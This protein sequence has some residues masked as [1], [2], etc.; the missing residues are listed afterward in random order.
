MAKVT[1]IVKVYV[2]GKLLR[3]KPG[4]KLK[5]GGK[6][7][8][9]VAGHSPY[10]YTEEVEFAELDCT[11]AHMADTDILELNELTE[12]TLRFETDTGQTLMVANAFTTEPCEIT[13]GEGDLTLKMMGDPAIEE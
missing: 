12:A 7:R 5:T 4:A 11:L 2:D 13:G 1:G 9:G 8:T 6:K 3:S 10:G